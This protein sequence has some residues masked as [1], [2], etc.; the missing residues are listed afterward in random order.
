MKPTE[1][2]LRT[3]ILMAAF[4][5][6][7]VAACLGMLAAA[8]ISIM[9]I[10]HPPSLWWLVAIAAVL[11]ALVWLLQTQT[12]ERDEGLRLFTTRL[13]TNAYDRSALIAAVIGTGLC[14]ITARDWLVPALLATASLLCLNLIREEPDIER[15]IPNLY[16]PLQSPETEPIRRRKPGEE[17]AEDTATEV[18][19][20]AWETVFTA[21]ESASLRIRLEILLARLNKFREKNPY[22]QTGQPRWPDFKEFVK[23]GVT[24]EMLEAAQQVRKFTD[25]N[26]W[27]AFHEVCAALALA[28]SI[29][30]S[31]DKNSTGLDEY[32]RYPIETL[33]DATGDC[34]D[35]SI[36]AGCLLLVLGHDVVM[37]LMPEHVAI[38]VAAGEGFPAGERL[39]SG[40]YY[41]CETTQEGWRVGQIPDGVN[42]SGIDVIRLG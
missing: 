36:L 10:E 39:V 5:G 29:P 17:G 15:G 31:L 25:D 11:G 37:L 22:R 30:Y 16:T 38:G 19:E 40:R 4:A 32:W 20:F 42:T 12:A 2:P 18:R 35:T 1:S 13:G 28:Q 9:A 41:Y 6:L 3:D 27:T 33:Y 23:G 24:T 14:L 8:T 26:D 34:E 7:G 21:E